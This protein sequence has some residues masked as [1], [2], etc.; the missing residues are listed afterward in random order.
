MAQ[1]AAERR[2]AQR[3]IAKEIK[4]GTF[5]PSPIGKK[6]RDAAKAYLQEKSELIK[7]IRE[8]KNQVYGG[9]AKFNQRRSDKN[10]RINPKTGKERFIEELRVIAY[11]CER[12]TEDNDRDNFYW[13]WD[14]I[15][16]DAEY[17]SAFY[18]H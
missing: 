13:Q 7:T 4:T 9:T 16:E 5:K 2:S 17:E 10:V 3:K 6:A 14:N 1:A 12:I 18:Y 11:T 15:F 8:Y